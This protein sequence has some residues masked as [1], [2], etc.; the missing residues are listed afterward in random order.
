MTKK[1]YILK[2]LNALDQGDSF[3]KLLTFIIEN[4]D[5]N[6]EELLN[7]IYEIIHSNLIK[8]NDLNNLKQIK[9]LF[10]VSQNI[11]KEIKES[12]NEKNLDNILLDI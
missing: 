1:E 3:I 2:L 9:N 7:N 12:E 5:E 4:I 10:L 8:I 11:K 6:N